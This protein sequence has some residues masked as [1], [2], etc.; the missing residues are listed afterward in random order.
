M[1]PVFFLLFSDYN[2]RCFTFSLFPKSLSCQMFSLISSPVHPL[3]LFLSPTC[4]SVGG[5]KLSGRFVI[6]FYPC[7]SSQS[8]GWH[9]PKVAVGGHLADVVYTNRNSATHLSANLCSPSSESSLGGLEA[10]KTSSFP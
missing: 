3:L 9:L 5:V 7:S 8:D 1:Q 4:L 6:V 2:S 10:S